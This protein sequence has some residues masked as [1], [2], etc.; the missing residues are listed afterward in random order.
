MSSEETKV[1]EIK[2]EDKKAMKPFI[3]MMVVSL[4]AGMIIGGIVSAIKFNMESSG[5]ESFALAWL[6]LQ[7]GMVLPAQILLAV[8]TVTVFPICVYYY[9]KGKKLWSAD[10]SEENIEIAE[11]EIEKSLFFSNIFLYGNYVLYS[12][13]AYMIYEQNM[14][15]D[16]AG[17]VI[18]LATTLLFLFDMVASVVMQGKIVNIVKE[19]NP[20]KQGSIYDKKFQEKWLE[21]CD[22]AQR[23]QIGQCSYKAFTFLNKICTVLWIL[24]TIAGMMF[25][26]GLV[27]HFVLGIIWIST[28]LVYQIEAMKVGK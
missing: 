1:E 23:I 16:G 14:L 24:L 5:E 8:F 9:K 3:I 21:S 17:R 15:Y 28:F 25:E 20:E 2:K 22:E 27:G 19:I 4:I 18:S 6:Q 13:A 7:K 26:I 11:N 12:V 10:K